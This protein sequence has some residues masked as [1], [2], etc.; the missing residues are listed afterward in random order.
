M[1]QR[2]APENT[3]VLPLPLW[4]DSP[5]CPAVSAQSLP[6]P[7]LLASPAPSRVEQHHTPLSSEIPVPAPQTGRLPHTLAQQILHDGTDGITP[8]NPR[9]TLDQRGAPSA[10]P[11]SPPRGSAPMPGQDSPDTTTPKR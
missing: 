1:P 5:S 4:H 8:P 3:V 2:G 11:A 10:V 9:L 6:A 7:V